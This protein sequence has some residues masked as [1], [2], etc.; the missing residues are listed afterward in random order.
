MQGKKTVTSELISMLRYPL[1]FF[2]VVQ[3]CYIAI[4]GWHYN[5]LSAQSIGSNVVSELMLSSKIVLSSAIC[6]FYTISGY[7]FFVHLKSWDS[8]VWK[9]KMS[10]RI[11]SLFI[12]YIIWNILYIL[13]QIG[14]E[15]ARCI[16]HGCSWDIVTSW[17]NVHGGWLGMFW[18]GKVLDSGIVNLWGQPVQFSGPVLL[19]FYFI[20]DLMVVSLFTPLLYFL[21]RARNHRITPCAVITIGFLTFFLLTQTSFVLSGFTAEAFFFYGLGA[22]L[23]LNGLELSEVFY[24]KRMLI[25][26]VTLSLFFA[27]LY[28]GFQASIAGI[29]I[30]PIYRVFEVMTVVNIASWMVKKSPTSKSVSALKNWFIK[31]QNASFMI[32]ALHVFFLSSVQAILNK[33]VDLVTEDYGV[34]SLEM[35][36]RYPCLVLMVYLA[37]IVVIVFICM[38]ASVL[39]EK[40]LPRLNKLVC[41]R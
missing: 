23:S 18:D 2:V 4:E 21:L 9:R 41:G 15:I 7:L 16:F 10:R 38:I 33:L 34:Y 19:P 13:F 20:R 39:M 5:Q 28:Y 35:S 11:W 12:P 36:T 3:H 22:F 30:H 31:W 32:Y 27:E 17:I 37:R 40:Y 8:N 25:G 6:I 1:A 29:I 24:P 26:I 14:P